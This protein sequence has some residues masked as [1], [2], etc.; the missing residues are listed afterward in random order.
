MKKELFTKKEDW[1]TSH[2]TM[3]V[4]GAT[5]EQIIE[6]AKEFDP[7]GEHFFNGEADDNG[8]I[9]FEV[10]T[11]DHRALCD[12]LSAQ[13]EGTVFYSFMSWE[14]H[15][16]YASKDGGQFTNYIIRTDEAPYIDD[17]SC[18]EDFEEDDFCELQYENIFSWDFT[19][20]T[21]EE[22]ELFSV[23]A[24]DFALQ[25]IDNIWNKQ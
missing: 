9:S 16:L 4:K 2:T 3:W 21:E 14:E 23:G 8:L 20:L 25:E 11:W 17:P 6:A 15:D 19:V 24:G 12:E 1:S 13:I 22:T 18:L 7:K 10:S 5:A